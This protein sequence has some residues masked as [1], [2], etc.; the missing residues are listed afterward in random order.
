MNSKTL[1]LLL[2][3]LFLVP[4]TPAAD[5]TYTYRGEVAGV[6]CSACSSHV[7]EALNKLP[8]VTSV[9]I[10]IADKEGLPKLVVISTSPDI[11]REAAVKALGEQAKMYDIR[12]LKRAEK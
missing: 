4:Q 8:G 10:T 1:L 6:M 7:K 9:K 3:T 2:L 11:T 12:S 5:P